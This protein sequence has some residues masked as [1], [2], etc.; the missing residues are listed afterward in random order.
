MSNRQPNFAVREEIVYMSM[1]GIIKKIIPDGSK[2]KYVVEF[3]HGKQTI[4]EGKLKRA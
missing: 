3:E 2:F 4:P 1:H